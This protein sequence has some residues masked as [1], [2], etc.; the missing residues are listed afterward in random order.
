MAFLQEDWQNLAREQ[1]NKPPKMSAMW[2]KQSQPILGPP[3]ACSYCT[4]LELFA[5][6]KFNLL[7]LWYIWKSASGTNNE[8]G[9]AGWF[10]FVGGL[11]AGLRAGGACNTRRNPKMATVKTPAGHT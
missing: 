1:Q 10:L 8:T 7:L 9:G 4:P 2:R 11:S 3:R 5:G 6:P